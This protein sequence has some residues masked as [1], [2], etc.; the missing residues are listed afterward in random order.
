MKVNYDIIAEKSSNE[1][2][3][4]DLKEYLFLLR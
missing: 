2:S 1:S 3:D 4:Y